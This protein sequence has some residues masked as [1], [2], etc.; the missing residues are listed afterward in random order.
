M[1]S[2]VVTNGKEQRMIL[3]GVREGEDHTLAGVTWIALNN[4]L[5]G[6]PNARDAPLDTIV[7]SMIEN[8]S[9]KSSHGLAIAHAI[10]QWLSMGVTTTDLIEGLSGD[11]GV[12]YAAEFIGRELLAKRLNLVYTFPGGGQNARTLRSIDTRI[13]TLAAQ[14]LSPSLVEY[15]LSN[16]ERRVSQDIVHTALISLVETSSEQRVNYEYGT[17]S[18]LAIG[19]M[20]LDRITKGNFRF[21]GARAL[22]VAAQHGHTALVELLLQRGADGYQDPFLAAAREGHVNIVRLLLPKIEKMPQA[23]LDIVIAMR[24]NVDNA[25]AINVEVVRT[26][27]QALQKYG[28]LTPRML[29]DVNTS[30]I[31]AAQWGNVE[32]VRLLVQAPASVEVL[33]T[34]LRRAAERNQND[35]IVRILIEAGATDFTRVLERAVRMGNAASL[36]ALIDAGANVNLDNGRILARAVAESN[37]DI[38]RI[39]IEN[40]VDVLMGDRYGEP[41]F[42]AANNGDA[43]IVRMLIDA[44]FTLSEWIN[45]A[46]PRA[47]RSNNTDTVHVLFERGAS[48]IIDP[49]LLLGAIKSLNVSLVHELLEHGVVVVEMHVD[50][51]VNG[52]PR[53][54]GFAKRLKIIADVVAHKEGAIHH[55]DEALLRAAIDDTWVDLVKMLIDAGADATRDSVLGEFYEF[56][57]KDNRWV[58][59]IV[60]ILVERGKLN[61]NAQNAKA[62]ELAAEKR[63]TKTVKLLL[64]LGAD[65]K[66]SDA[67]IGAARGGAPLIIIRALLKAG[68]DVHRRDDEALIAAVKENGLPTVRELLKSGANANARNGLAM[69]IAVEQKY[70]EISALLL[71]YSVKKEQVVVVKREKEEEEEEEEENVQKRQKTKMPMIASTTMNLVH[72]NDDV[73]ESIAQLDISSTCDTITNTEPESFTLLL[74]HLD[75]RVLDCVRQR[76]TT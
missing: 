27:Y 15:M 28:E 45:S 9:N 70:T 44:G 23:Q 67:L 31:S 63:R 71:Q 12:L 33:N 2:S 35:Q 10:E 18:M 14:N 73:S 40:G 69:S 30:L 48:N 38:V 11:I 26:L 29:L 4:F 52:I 8:P 37:T 34:A 20:L 55:N 56:V 66:D 16:K 61:V 57:Q 3:S 25:N 46:L 62:L 49:M 58:E 53:S 19:K 22:R 42:T 47:I 7:D 36:H 60:R 51:L 1:S 5:S 72:H 39:L 17:S 75:A 21:F 50:E 59:K 43:E 32:I 41:L 24:R 64:E 6:M 68:A 74:K 76:K 65:A 13:L 54:A